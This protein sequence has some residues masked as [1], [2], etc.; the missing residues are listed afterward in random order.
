MLADEAEVAAMSMP[1]PL[2]LFP[3]LIQKLSTLETISSVYYG[4]P[5]I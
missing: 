3:P 4:S 2:R 1:Y 5:L